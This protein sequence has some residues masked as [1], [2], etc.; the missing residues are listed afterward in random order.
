MSD[1]ASTES[2]PPP[3]EV[4]RL[5]RWVKRLTAFFIGQ[6]SVQL[7]NILTGF[8]LLR[9]MTT[10]EYAA[11]TLVNGFQGSV[12]VLVEM[13]LGS[14]IIALLAGRT[15]AATVGGYIRSV[16]HY[17]DTF[18]LVMVPILIVSFSVLTQRQ[19]WGW[20]ITAGLLGAVLATLYFQSWA[21]YYSVP[22]VIHHELGKFY[23]ISAGLGVFRLGVCLLLY[24]L[25]SLTALLAAWLATV[26][27]V[28]MG[29]FYRR[30]STRLI[31][32]PAKSD[33]V[34]N[35]QVLKYIRPQI[36]ATIFF[37][38]Q[39]Q[40]NVLLI[41]WFGQSRSIAEVGA[42]G[43]I[44]QLFVLL[45]AF[46][47]IIV[48]P[49]IARTRRELLLRRY[50]LM[51]ALALGVCAVLLGVAFFLPRPFL[52]LLGSKYDHLEHE[53]GWMMLSSCSG[54]VT[55]VMFTMHSARKWIFTWGSWAYIGSVIVTQIA[56]LL[57]MDLSTTRGVI[58]FG[59]YSSL[60][61][62]L[63]Q[64]VWGAVGFMGKGKDAAQ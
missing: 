20:G 30:Q 5:R 13:G 37:A 40:V 6:G 36:P 35:R 4:S 16:R 62:L 15:D 31:V 50:L 28:V 56:G 51:V 39:G 53:L 44:G 48:I 10:E 12:G 60:A 24:L 1:A 3:P 9:W 27:T 43:R 17:R 57:L 55:G 52:W 8:L 18:F 19:G 22:L 46:N 59:V 21:T 45:A 63:V 58:I 26:T 23:R 25:S 61:T 34:K 2:A 33:P 49:M 41:T 29:V 11:Y 54:Y 7:I 64:V 38:L 42:L 32:E 14:S 47:N